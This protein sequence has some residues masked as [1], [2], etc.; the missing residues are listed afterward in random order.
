M[1]FVSGLPVDSASG[2]PFDRDGL[3]RDRAALR[4]SVAHRL[5][6]S[7][8][9]DPL[10]AT[11]RDWL[12]A[13]ALAARDRPPPP[14]LVVRY[15]LVEGWMETFRAHAERDVKRVYYLS[16]EFLTGRLL[17]NSLLNLGLQ[18][19]LKQALADLEVALDDVREVEQDAAL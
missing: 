8:G 17:S 3:G 13:T 1:S 15:R 14:A 4:Q 18:D 16:M 2:S 11:A 7:L 6:Y 12:H 19:E 10:T 9:K 5:V